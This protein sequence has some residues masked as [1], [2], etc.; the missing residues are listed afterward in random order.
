VRLYR[1][2]PYGIR[3]LSSKNLPF[4]PGVNLFLGANGQGKTNYLEMIYLLATLKSF[5]LAKREDI[6]SWGEQELKIEAAI[7]SKELEK[8]ISLQWNHQNRILKIN[9][10]HEK[11]LGNYFSQIKAVCFSPEDLGVLHGAPRERRRFM[12]RLVFQCHP[13][14]LF[15]VREYNRVLK[16]RNACLK[17]WQLNGGKEPSELS[18]WTD[19]M[20][21]QAAQ[22]TLSRIDF[23]Q[24]MNKTL[25]N[26]YAKVSGRESE[27]GVLEGDIHIERVLKGKTIEVMAPSYDELAKEYQN[28]YLDH[29]SEERIR[30]LS[31]WGPHLEDYNLFYGRL[32]AGRFAST[33]QKKTL[34]LALR[35]TEL[36]LVSKSFQEAPLL[37]LDD[38]S[39]ELD[40]KRL[41]TLISF[42]AE[43]MEMFSE[44]PQVFITTVSPNFEIFKPLGEIHVFQVEQGNLTSRPG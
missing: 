17:K 15:W 1:I 16:Q 43:E 19:K 40:A 20:I 12:D 2:R 29:A 3:N 4:F 10:N 21:M 7:Q 35:L 41:D 22:L 26:L 6:Q 14:H 11:D 8:E 39:A 32:L 34:L 5:R 42:L 28:N 37:L 33:G 38:L 23:L 44:S 31:L 18:A 27:E 36:E 24:E 30:G 13:Q 25:P 9:G